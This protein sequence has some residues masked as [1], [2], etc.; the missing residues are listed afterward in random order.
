MMAWAESEDEIGGTS[1]G[2]PCWPERKVRSRERTQAGRG[3]FGAAQEA[4]A[5]LWMPWEESQVSSRP[6]WWT[7]GGWD[8][9]PGTS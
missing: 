9:R 8:P 1:K 2:L 5:P 6:G 3:G 7:V 4:G